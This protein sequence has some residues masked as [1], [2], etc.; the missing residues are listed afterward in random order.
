[1]GRQKVELKKISRMSSGVYEG[2]KPETSKKKAFQ[3]ANR[4]NNFK[5]M[6]YGNFKRHTTP[7]ETE[8]RGLNLLEEKSLSLQRTTRFP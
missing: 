8:N 2:L 1:M 5:H 7:F 4:S 6:P 3:S